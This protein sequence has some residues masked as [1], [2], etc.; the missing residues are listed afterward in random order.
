MMAHEKKNPRGKKYTII[1]QLLPQK[2]EGEVERERR[3]TRRREESRKRGINGE[4]ERRKKRRTQK[5]RERKERKREGERKRLC[6]YL[7]VAILFQ[8]APNRK[9]R[10]QL[11]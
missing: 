4:G 2:W 6:G 1:C 7:Q 3:K 11:R 10:A 5:E 9:F 8:A